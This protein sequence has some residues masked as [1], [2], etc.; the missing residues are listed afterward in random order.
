MKLTDKI[1]TLILCGLFLPAMVDAAD[2]TVPMYHVYELSFTGTPLN[3]SDSPVRDVILETRWEHEDGV[4]SIKLYGFWDGD[5]RGGPQGSVFKV[6]F[7]PTKT[8][9]WKLES[10]S[11]ND[12]KLEGQHEGMILKCTDSDHPGFWMVDP[13]SKGGRW[14]ITGCL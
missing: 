13:D 9:E 14:F 12:R 11:S 3:V 8:G 7:C 6:R 2:D 10:V 5:G 1:L 4:T